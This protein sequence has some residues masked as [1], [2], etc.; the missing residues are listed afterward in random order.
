M[1]KFFLATLLLV[2][3]LCISQVKLD[4]GLVAYFPFNGNALDESGNS[5]HP[6]FNNATLTAG[7]SGV[8]NTAYYFNGVNNYMRIVSNP[9]L[10]PQQITLYARVK[11]MGFYQGTCY[12]NVILDKGVYDFNPGNY[13]LRYTQGTYTNGS[14][15]INDTIHQN[16]AGFCGTGNGGPPLH[17]PYVQ[18]NVWYDIV[19]TVATDSIKFYVNGE[20]KQRIAR[21]SEIGIN[22]QDVFL[23]MKNLTNY[24][25]WFK[26]VMDEIRIYNRALTTTEAEA[27]PNHVI[28]AGT[29]PPSGPV[30]HYPFSGNAT[31]I[32]GNNNNGTV[33]NAT[34]TTDRFG[35]PNSAYNFNGTNAYIHVPNSTSLQLNNSIST[36]AY[37]Y[38]NA[39]YPGACHGNSILAKGMSHVSPNFFS[40]SYTD[41]YYTNGQNCN[42]AVP[43]AAHHNFHGVDDWPF[44]D[45]V[46]YIVP[47]KWYC[48]IQTN[49]GVTAKLYVNGT[50]QG[51]GLKANRTFNNSNP[52]LI[53][54]YE[55]SSTPYWLN[56]VIDDIL[57][58]K[59]A[60]T[61]AEIDSLTGNLKRLPRPDSLIVTS[62]P[63]SA[64]LEWTAVAGTGITYKI[65]RGTTATNLTA[66]KTGVT[67]TTFQDSMLTAPQY[68]YSVRAIDAAGIQGILSNTAGAKPAKVIWVANNGS[69]VSPADG[70]EA[71]PY[72]T[73]VH[74][75]NQA[76]S[77]DTI[78]LKPGVYNETISINK[79]VTIASKMIL[80][81]NK[82]YIDSTI[83]D[84]AGFPGVII[85]QVAAGNSV[86]G[87]RITGFTLKNA[88]GTALSLTKG[89]VV[90][91]TKFINNGSVTTSS[92]L[93]TTT[94]DEITIDN[95]LFENNK[96][97][98]LL[99]TAHVSIAPLVP[100]R[101]SNCTFIDNQLVHASFGAISL[102]T[103]ANLSN[104]LMVRNKGIGAGISFW[105]NTS[106]GSTIADSI[107]L[108]H[109]TI[110]NSAA[111]NLMISGHR[112]SYL[113]IVNSISAYAANNVNISFG[114]PGTHS[115]GK[116][117]VIFKSFLS[118]TAVADVN[119]IHYD[120][121]SST[122]LTE[123]PQFKDTS[124]N[125]YRLTS[126]SVGIGTGSIDTKNSSTDIVGV[127][128]PLPV[129][130]LPDIGAFEDSVATKR[131]ET[132]IRSVTAGNKR[133]T[134]NWTHQPDTSIIRKFRLYRRT[135]S[136][137]ASVLS[138]SI[139]R[140]AVS[141]VDSVGLSNDTTY[142]Y[143]IAP[144]DSTGNELTISN[145]MSG[146]P[147]NRAPIASSLN[148]KYINIGR[149][150]YAVETLTSF[151]SID[152]DGRIDSTIWYMNGTRVAI[153]DSVQLSVPQGTNTISFIIHDNDGGKD[154]AVCTRT[155]Y[156]SAAT[157]NNNVLT[158]LSAYNKAN[159]FYA[160]QNSTTKQVMRADSLLAP[161][162]N[163]GPSSIMVN[164]NI[165]SAPP[166][167]PDSIMFIPNG[168]T[169]DAFRINGSP[170]FASSASLGGLV[171]VPPTID[172]TLKRVYLGLSN[173]TWLALN[174]SAQS[175]TVAWSY[176][177]AD[178]TVGFSSPGVI[179]ADRK[180]IYTT[181]S[182]V[183][184][185]FDLDSL[186]TSN[187]VA[188]WNLAV[189]RNV[190]KS[191]A[192][193]KLGAVIVTDDLGTMHK[194]RLDSSGSITEL[195]AKSFTGGKY[196]TA[197]VID[198]NNN[199]YVGTDNGRI[200]KISGATGDTM[201]SYNSGFPITATPALS[202]YGTVIFGTSNGEAT[203]LFTI[204]G[205]RKWRF[206]MDTLS[207]ITAHMMHISGATYFTTSTTKKIYQIWDKPDNVPYRQADN[208]MTAAPTVLEP[209]WGGYQGDYRGG[210]QLR[211]VRT[212]FIGNGNWNIAS[213]W[214][215][216]VVPPL[217]VPKGYHITISPVVDGVCEVD[218]PVTLT[219]GSTLRIA[220][221]KKL[222]LK[223]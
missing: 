170:Y 88:G 205:S 194:Y 152:H 79:L 137:T 157:A 146:K 132:L 39:F 43:D 55:N 69:N 193:D 134:I 167:S 154:T 85:N 78:I 204:N 148:N 89:S 18:T 44:A 100:V 155:F 26:G 81:G 142:F 143:K 68:Y 40:L 14:C 123:D 209:V 60:L 20:I 64:K 74:A 31:D 139:V 195:W 182:G 186:N 221:E 214:I 163:G 29:F 34:L 56:G 77:G 174:Y 50:L 46:S 184:K 53:G 6:I 28:P 109:V 114:H 110:A 42:I 91:H 73:L 166:V 216:G 82:A 54:R 212:T 11:P 98:S 52:L 22:S 76:I 140:T 16:F 105:Q 135:S 180:L 208:L 87:L 185:G 222:I 47:G 179:T 129:G 127:A 45:S 1:R 171:Q 136:T 168:S 61:L 119:L 141:Y 32:S 84:G 48:V 131:P 21:V 19:Y 181:T 111:K 122:I 108:N 8:P 23:G 199:I 153:G 7:K 3:Q 121:A 165:L 211:E 112:N 128:R 161:N 220:A 83:I 158:G 169:L 175:P 196:N 177:H 172:A 66:Y 86:S 10:N 198:G 92:S 33:Y 197:A 160:D 188:K 117:K 218:S 207:P 125:N 102:N 90:S 124:L 15:Y 149:N 71:K 5:N 215:D 162:F 210:G 201:W 62:G 25:Y 94:A 126:L 2:S 65:Y 176:F 58:Y 120:T 223:K 24:N 103:S 12:N 164:N 191:M 99:L 101:I 130:S 17:Q 9:G 183:I 159:I 95:C 80:T 30:A 63:R 178:Q 206:Q 67:T 217:N 13:T 151:G 51:S 97:V 27:L 4:S 147:F 200:V 203:A 192:V 107:S 57:I 38:V 116:P 190:S 150:L 145:E 133:M 156:A 118:P 144:I 37:V 96:Y 187:P 70:S 106:T 138:D 59:R 113:K 189:G 173:G 202:N 36:V 93:I 41:H 49:D 115:T 104:I 72:Q 35:N 219:P 75:V 213:N